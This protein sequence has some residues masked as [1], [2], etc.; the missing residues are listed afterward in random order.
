MQLKVTPPS[1]LVKVMVAVVSCVNEPLAGPPVMAVSGVVLSMTTVTVLAGVST[2]PAL[3]VAEK[4]MVVVPSA[5][6]LIGSAVAAVT[7]VLAIV[8]APDAL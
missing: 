6:M 2:L 3:S 5:V 4:V 8:V 7:V 1:L